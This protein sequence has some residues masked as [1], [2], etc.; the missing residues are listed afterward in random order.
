MLLLL[1]A[2]FGGADDT[3]PGDTS[4]ESGDTG[5][6]SGD[7]ADSGENGVVEGETVA[8]PG[9]TFA[10]GCDDCDADEAPV[11]TVTLSAFTIDR[12][13]VTVGQYTAC[14][15]AGACEAP[16][17]EVGGE[18]HPVTGLAYDEVE[19]FCAWRGMSVPTEA[20]WEFAARGDDG[21]RYPWGDAAPDC[22]LAAQRACT[23]GLEPVGGHPSGESPFGV[24]DLSG[25]AWEWV[26]DYYDPDYYVDSPTE[27]PPGG[28]AG[29]LRTV[30]G[31]DLWSDAGVLRASNREY[32]I[33][34]G[35]SVVV[36]FRCA[37][38]P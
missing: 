29:G 14:V 38:S 3:G 22:T 32:A 5:V 31:V 6:D 23:G 10:M 16:L 24:A 1:F 2:C 34:D 28:P 19:A 35:R 30:R 17:G 37:G 7:T 9:G 18:H 33:P 12:Y 20:E 15:E 4:A 11:H 26:S 36:G 27:N 21:R 8:I 25:N 13:E